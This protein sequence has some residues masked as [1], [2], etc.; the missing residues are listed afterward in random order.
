MGKFKIKYTSKFADDLAGLIHFIKIKGLKE[1]ACKHVEK[2]YS[3]IESLNFE[4]IDYAYCREVTRANAGLKCVRYNAKYT[5]VFY[6]F[7][8]EVII[9]EFSPSKMLFI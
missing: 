8:D 7:S 6:P 2:V 1:T 3:C 4:K 9:T 5:E